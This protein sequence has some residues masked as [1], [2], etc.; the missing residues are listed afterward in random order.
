[1]DG[2]M[3]RQIDDRYISG[4]VDEW[5]EKEKRERGKKKGKKARRK[6]VWTD[7]KRLSLYALIISFMPG[8]R[9]K[10]LCIALV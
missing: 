4:Q 7:R 6:E 9:T 10:F 1:M 3:E 2:W 8:H 5:K